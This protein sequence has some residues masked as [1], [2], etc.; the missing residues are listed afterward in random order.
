MD[1][2]R[3]KIYDPKYILGSD[4]DVFIGCDDGNIYTYNL[5]TRKLRSLS[6][7]P[8]SVKQILQF[9]YG[10]LLCRMVSGYETTYFIIDSF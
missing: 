3:I 4:D 7:H 10:R 6:K 8:G 2:K 9:S 1:D 5:K